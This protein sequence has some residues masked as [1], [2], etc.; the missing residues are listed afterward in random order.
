MF[1]RGRIEDRVRGEWDEVP[2]A[3]GFTLR[4]DAK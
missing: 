1:G 4:D 2:D 3:L